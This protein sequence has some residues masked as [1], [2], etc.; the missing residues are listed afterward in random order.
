VEGVKPGIAALDV[1]YSSHERF[2]GPG[3]VE[4]Y[5]ELEGQGPAIT[6]VNNFFMISPAWRGYTRNLVQRYRLLTYDLRNQG[7][8]SV[9]AKPPRVADHINDLRQLLGGLGIQPTYLLG[10]SIS[11]VITVEFARLHPEMVKGLILV[12]PAI[13]PYGPHRRTYIT[14]AWLASL[15]AGGP[16]A[17][18]NHLYPM[19]FGDAAI[20]TGGTGT[21]LTLKENFLALNS[22]EQLRASLLG[23]M[24][25]R[26]GPEL[27][28]QIS[29]PTLL[30]VGDGDFH[31][32][33]SVLQAARGLLQR[34]RAEVIAGAGH[35]PFFDAPAAFE[36]AVE[37]FVDEC[38]AA[39]QR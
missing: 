39:P 31:W 18:F 8:S 25:A 4:L 21:Y 34:E 37:A 32:S 20:E 9:S 13:S 12:G 29:C 26:D 19:V 38:E 22:Q 17:L 30:L 7:A 6:F 5:Y 2:Q 36:R 11:A 14:R 28:R 15:E 27:F 24:A 1:R 3:G 35:V 33:A 23:A 16:V 10:T